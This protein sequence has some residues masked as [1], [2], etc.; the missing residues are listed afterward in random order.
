MVLKTIK[1]R[2]HLSKQRLEQIAATMEGMKSFMKEAM[3]GKEP[4]VKLPDELKVILKLLT[5][6]CPHF[7]NFL[8]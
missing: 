6:L 8:I 4:D 5:R 2:E 1:R 3:K 7:E